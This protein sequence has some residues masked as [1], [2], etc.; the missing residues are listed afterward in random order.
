L[1]LSSFLLDTINEGGDAATF[2]SQL[3]L[4]VIRLT[5]WL[6]CSVFGRL[7]VSTPLRKLAS[8]LSLHYQGTSEGH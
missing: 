6:A 8:A 4:M 3:V 2:T 1:S 7:T 5:F